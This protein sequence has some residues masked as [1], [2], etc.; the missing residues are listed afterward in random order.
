MRTLRILALIAVGVS[1]HLDKL[2][3]GGGGAVQPLSKGTPVGLA[4]SSLPRAP[5][6]GPL[7]PVQ[8][9]VV[10]SGGQPVAGADSITVTVALASNPAGTT[11]QGRLDTH[12]ARGVATFSDLRLDRATSGYALTAAANGLPSVT[13]DTFAVVPGPAAQLTFTVGPSAVSQGAVVAPPVVVTAFDSLDNAA[14][15]FTGDVRLVLRQNGT[16]VNGALSGGTATAVAGVATF[17]NLR[18]NNA[19]AAYTLAAAFGGAAP[20]AESAPFTVTPPGPP[21]PPSGDLAVTTTTTGSN[22]PS[23]YTVTVDGTSVR[24]IGA[25]ASVTISQVPAGSH[26]VGLGDVPTTC[27]VTGD[28]PQTVTVPAA[29]T[30]RGDFVITCGAPP[31]PPPPRPG[32]YLLFTDEPVITQAGQ[33]MNIVRV[34]T[35]DAA[36]NQFRYLGDV[37]ISIGFNP[38]GGTLTGGG[39]ITMDPGLGGVVQWER[40]SIDKPGFGYTLHATS[41]GMIE[42]FSDPLDI[43]AG[44]PPSPNGADGLGIFGQQPTTTRA[45]DLIVPIRIGALGPPNGSVITAYTGPVWI[46][47]GTNPGGATLTGTRRLMVV[48]G[49]VTFSDLR[50]DKPGSGYILRATAWP[51]NYTL[52]VPFTVVP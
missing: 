13:S 15:D 31:P 44:P 19:G 16:V 20:L 50:I 7:G 38:S 42:A 40:L 22:L 29:G 2:L 47:L 3:N 51:L 18:I 5:R 45:G 28:N 36:G 48:N 39:T 8:V 1:C 23:G 35:Y 52:S 11:L 6:A 12:P 41:P 24:A 17:A 43:T 26:R 32:P 30:A 10:D 34:T 4:F 14:T 49:F 9:S 33:P 25:S 21:P 46:S 27:A 37:T